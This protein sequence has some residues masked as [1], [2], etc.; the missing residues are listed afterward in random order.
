MI[1]IHLF[2]SILRKTDRKAFQD[3]GSVL[4]LTKNRNFLTNMNLMN[5]MN[6]NITFDRVKFSLVNSGPFHFTFG[7]INSIWNNLLLNI[8]CRR[9]TVKSIDVMSTEGLIAMSSLDWFPQKWGLGSTDY[10]VRSASGPVSGPVSGP[11][12]YTSVRIG[13]FFCG[14]GHEAFHRDCTACNTV[15]SCI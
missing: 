4:E 13:P 12:I 11:W 1:T 8:L 6:S 7:Q 15:F 2:S 14:L 9:N 5:L 10:L 3:S